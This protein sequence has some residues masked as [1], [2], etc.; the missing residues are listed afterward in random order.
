M[1]FHTKIVGVTHENRQSLISDLY[2]AGKLAPETKLVLRR[3]PNN[4]YDVFAV[5]VLT[6]DGQQLGYVS[7]EI[8]KDM[9]VGMYIGIEYQAYVTS[10]TGGNDGWNYGINLRIECGE[11]LKESDI[12]VEKTKPEEVLNEG[13]ISIFDIKAGT[14]LTHKKLGECVVT[15]VHNNT[16]RVRFDG[17]AE[18]AFIL[19]STPTFFK[20]VSAPANTSC[21]KQPEPVVQRKLFTPPEEDD[22]D[23]D[24]EDSGPDEESYA[25]YY[26]DDEPF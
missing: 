10:V 14:R 8:A 9:S 4:P 24:I 21:E 17:G 7:K 22:Y 12:P 15:S 20:G 3:E 11:A 6:K 1:Q 23:Y 19:D 13:T 26:E 16:L 18:K 2:C 25:Y 5:A